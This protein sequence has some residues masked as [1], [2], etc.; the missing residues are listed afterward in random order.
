V[1]SKHKLINASSEF[2]PPAYI[3]SKKIMISILNEPCHGGGVKL[4]DVIE[5]ELTT[6]FL[7]FITL[8]LQN[9]TFDPKSCR[10]LQWPNEYNIP[11]LKAL[12]PMTTPC[13]SPSQV[14]ASQNLDTKH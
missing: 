8:Q 9:N 4:M 6:I 10:Q 12:H 11:S 14:C 1:E 5:I 7:S 3:K 13:P 2:T